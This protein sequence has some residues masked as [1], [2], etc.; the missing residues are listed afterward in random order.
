MEVV[1]NTVSAMHNSNEMHLD[2]MHIYIII[3]ILYI[4]T[5]ILIYVNHTF[6]YI[7]LCICILYSGLENSNGTSISPTAMIGVSV[8][9]V[10]MLIG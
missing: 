4:Y 5:Y 6:K 8:G 7:K 3:Y 10:E 1:G 9:C 2:R